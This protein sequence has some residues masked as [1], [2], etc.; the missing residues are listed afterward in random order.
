MIIDRSKPM[1]A[2]EFS[3]N[4]DY[5]TIGVMHD[6]CK[7]SA[8]AVEVLKAVRHMLYEEIAK[9]DNEIEELET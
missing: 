4:F 2:P 7:T 9:L 5:P 6:S 1:P 3:I 8:R